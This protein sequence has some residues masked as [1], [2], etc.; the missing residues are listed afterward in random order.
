[1]ER[2]EGGTEERWL[3]RRAQDSMVVKSPRWRREEVYRSER[4]EVAG[5]ATVGEEKVVV[6]EVVVEARRKIGGGMRGGE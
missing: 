6:G 3:E 4:E 5:V 1:M 2:Q